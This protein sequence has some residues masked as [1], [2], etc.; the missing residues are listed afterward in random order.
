MELARRALS[1]SG[2]AV[3]GEHL[4]NPRTGGAAAR[5][6]RAW[7]FALSGAVADAL[8]TAFFVMSD[9]EVAAYCV[10][11]AEVGAV[12]AQAED[13]MLGYGTLPADLSSAIN[14]TPGRR[15]T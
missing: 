2:L 8:S 7:A 11:E 3:K 9:A 6:E 10:D 4:I 12:L 14:T 1:G 5:R 15:P 13:K